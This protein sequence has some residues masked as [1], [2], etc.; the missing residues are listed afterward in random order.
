MKL[1]YKS[2]PVAQLVEQFPFKEWVT[3]SN[4]VGLTNK[5]MFYYLSCFKCKQ[6]VKVTIQDYRDKKRTYCDRCLSKAFKKIKK[7]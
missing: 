2:G 4:L 1:I 6:R 7:I 3:S 5:Y